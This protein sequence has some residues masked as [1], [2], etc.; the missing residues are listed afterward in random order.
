MR[1]RRYLE[2]LL[3]LV[4]L[5]NLLTLLLL[6]VFRVLLRLRLSHETGA[7]HVVKLLE[8]SVLRLL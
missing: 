1:G 3:L 7:M 2:L 5:Q 4:L 8:V 6:G